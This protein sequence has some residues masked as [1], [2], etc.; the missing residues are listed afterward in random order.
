MKTI[1]KC[2]VEWFKADLGMFWA[3]L[4]RPWPPNNCSRAEG[5][6]D[7]WLLGP[8]GWRAYPSLLGRAWLW[9]G[10]VR[11]W[12]GWDWGIFAVWLSSVASPWCTAP[13]F[14][15]SSVTVWPVCVINSAALQWQYNPLTSGGNSKFLKK[16][17]QKDGDAVEWVRAAFL[18][19]CYRTVVDSKLTETPQLFCY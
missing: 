13:C 7:G 16:P 15:T 3:A 9:S 2:G 11:D 12:G 6:P 10:L 17:W 4:D 1:L 18:S 5:R 14:A 8:I 19:G